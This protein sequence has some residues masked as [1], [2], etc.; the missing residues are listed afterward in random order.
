MSSNSSV[1]SIQH[2]LSSGFSAFTTAEEVIKGIDL[3]GKTAIVT[4]GYSGIGAETTRVLALAGASVI[5]PA[6]DVIRATEALKDVKGKIEVLACDLSSKSSIQGFV[7]ALLKR[8]Q[9]IHLLVNSAGIMALPQ[10]TLDSRGLELQFATNHLG[11]FQLT[12]GILPLLRAAKG[13]RVVQV[14]S[15]A[16]RIGAFDFEDHTFEKREY[17]PFLA[18]GMSKCANV[19]FALALDKAER[20]NGIRAFSVHPGVI[21]TNLDR[22]LPAG[23]GKNAGIADEQ[24]NYKID[25][26]SGFKT[27]QQGAATQVFGAV[28]PLLNGLGG[29]YLE[30]TDVSPILFTADLSMPKPGTPS[31][32]GVRPHAIDDADAARLWDLS[33]KLLA[34]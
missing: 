32:L 25:P 15:G 12:T 11:H 29:V 20:E 5:V 17:Q 7:D 2:P 28:S 19:L 26:A 10:R 22:H 33:I 21:Q 23:F 27:V 24:G 14:S 34:Q 13:A 16:H 8:N 18:Y 6:R 3:S 31:V 1:A 9:P 4:G 30:D